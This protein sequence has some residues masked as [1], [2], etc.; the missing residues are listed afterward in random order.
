MNIHRGRDGRI[1]PLRTWWALWR[2]RTEAGDGNTLPA[3]FGGVAVVEDEGEAHVA[4]VL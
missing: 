1:R 4:E 2:L 3:V